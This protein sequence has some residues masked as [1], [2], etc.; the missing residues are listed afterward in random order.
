MYILAAV[1][2]EYDYSDNPFYASVYADLRYATNASGKWKIST[3]DGS[4]SSGWYSSIV[5]DSSGNVHISY[6]DQLN[7]VIKYATNV[8]RQLDNYRRIR[9]CRCSSPL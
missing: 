2:I 9:N 4:G 8:S 1:F 3:V 5:L 6:C 7:Y